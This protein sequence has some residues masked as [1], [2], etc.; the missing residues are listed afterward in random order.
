MEFYKEK[1][2]KYIYSI[3]DNTTYYENN[4]ISKL[5]IH[6]I[7]KPKMIQLRKI[8]YSIIENDNQIFK[9]FTNKSAIFD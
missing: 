6:K 8:E 4:S 1:L 3:I 5:F 2:E 9:V 7:L